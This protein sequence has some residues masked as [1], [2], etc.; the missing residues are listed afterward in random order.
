MVHHTKRIHH[1][2]TLQHAETHYNTRTS[3]THIYGQHRHN[4]Q[5]PKQAKKFERKRWWNLAMALLCVMLLHARPAVW[6]LRG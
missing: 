5:T 4:T 2:N 6:V 1:G 3:I